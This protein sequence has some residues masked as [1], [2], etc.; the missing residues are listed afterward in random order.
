MGISWWKL[1]WLLISNIV[2]QG[3]FCTPYRISWLARPWS[4]NQYWCCTTNLEATT[5]HS[6]RTSNSCTL[7]VC[8][9]LMPCQPACLLYSFNTVTISFC[10]A[11]IGRTG[12][13]ITIH[14]TIERILIGDKRSYDIVETVK[15]F[16][17]Q[18]PG[19]V[20]TEVGSAL[21]P[22]LVWPVCW[23]LLYSSD[24]VELKWSISNAPQ[25]SWDKTLL[26]QLFELMK[27]GVATKYFSHIIVFQKVYFC[28]ST[29]ER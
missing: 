14:T 24:W 15:N 10:S 18:R 3:S 26:Q 16:R 5:S 21:F 25:L 28:Y 20:Q 29:S 23:W 12:T 6:N 11:G 27:M 13:Y 8:F 2:R 22:L 19:M 9:T 17:S 1:F 7:Q 4:A